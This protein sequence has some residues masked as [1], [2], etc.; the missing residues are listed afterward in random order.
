MPDH[1]RLPDP[2]RIP[3]RRS[4]GGPANVVPVRRAA[5][6]AQLV[7]H[8]DNL[9][10][11]AEEVG[12]IDTDF[13]L[14]LSGRTRLNPPYAKWK[15]VKVGEGPDW[16]YFV[17]ASAEARQ[18]LRQLFED[19]AASGDDGRG[20]NHA[21]TW[22]EFV[23]D[24]TG[25]ELYGPEDR[26]HPSL[27][28]LTFDSLELLDISIWPSESIDEAGRRIEV[29]QSAIEY[30]GSQ[31]GGGRLVTFDPRPE[32]TM[33]RVLA[34]R[35]L[36]E[37]M[38]RT[39]VVQLVREPPRP[40]LGIS[41]LFQRI[42]VDDSG[43]TGSAVG[44][45]DDGVITENRYLHDVVADSKSFPESYVFAAPTDHGS[46]VCGL[47]AYGDFEAS[48]VGGV[49]L[50]AP[51][52]I[53]HARVL[54]PDGNGRTRFAPT[55]LH[56]VTMN[57]AIRWM[58]EEYQIRV[59]V[60]AISDPWTHEGPLVDEWTQILDHL[61]RDLDVVIVVPA[62][63]RPMPFGEQLECGCHVLHDY[64]NY[65]GCPSGRLAAP[66]IGALVVT[67]GSTTPQGSPANE[68]E[69]VVAGP[70]RPSPFTRVGPGPGRSQ[71]GSRKPEFVAV[72][73][74]WSYDRTLRR[75]SDRDPSLNV[76]S[77]IRPTG[78]RELGVVSGTSF[79][80]PRVA[81]A[82]AAIASR[83]PSSS[84]NMLRALAAIGASRSDSLNLE[85]DG[86][87]A[88]DFGAYGSI[89]VE[90]SVESAGPR[91]VLTYEGEIAADSVEIHR[92]PMPQRFLEG[93]T[94]RTIKVALAFDPPVR[95]Q[96][97]EYIAGSMS[98]DLVR[99][100]S[101]SNLTEAYC[102]QPTRAQSE[103]LGIPRRGLP[104]GRGLLLP[105]TSKFSDNTLICRRFSSSTSWDEDVLDYFVIVTHQ[106]SS[107]S[108][109]QK[110]AYESQRYALAI[111]MSDEGRLEMNL[112]ALV[113]ARLLAQA[114][115]RTR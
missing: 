51:H 28:E 110:R 102:R 45:I 21:K 69:V 10:E 98:V 43:P 67:V 55:V 24:L 97:R 70:G 63:N 13:I 34:D 46:A 78:N 92:V 8:L 58:V 74:N 33:I 83:Y 105:G 101:L 114:R 96:R 88:F 94:P 19:Y 17:L 112:Y 18:T 111:E 80:A 48:I 84:A 113:R 59:I 56:H 31:P 36:L 79:A 72:G 9:D 7:R 115:V 66:G 82:I 11:L 47:A 68:N 75:V 30:R 44:V 90:H 40:R 76:V 32:T 57:E 65:L 77:T 15:L 50:P 73:G 108:P 106:R 54:E 89:N 107:W 91:V 42:Q 87:F 100:S 26:A 3:T 103:E 61:S 27:G 1:L 5:H 4:G 23:R 95:R 37:R 22:S 109:A 38:L 35:Q 86:V 99:G 49:P 16:S 81:N 39:S 52:P 93:Y 12:E 6:G 29:V 62:G 60:A 41:Q 20:W 71:E 85:V 104:A 64:P 25:I 53:I 14:K 2:H